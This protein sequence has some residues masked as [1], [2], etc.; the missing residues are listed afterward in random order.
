MKHLV[1]VLLYTYHIRLHCVYFS[2]Y[3]LLLEM[4]SVSHCSFQKEKKEKE[5]ET[6]LHFILLEFGTAGMKRTLSYAGS[7]SV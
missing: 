1:T 3:S 6:A 5:K 2:V 7:A 4:Y